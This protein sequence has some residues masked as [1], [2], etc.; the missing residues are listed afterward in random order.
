ML[1]PSPFL[2]LLDVPVFNDLIIDRDLQ[3]KVIQLV[4]NFLASA[5][6]SDLP[7]VVR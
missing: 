4:L 3:D 5:K 6:I 2:T 7:I 1:L